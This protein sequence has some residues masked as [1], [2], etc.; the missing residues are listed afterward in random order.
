EARR[1]KEVSDL[2]N[3]GRGSLNDRMDAQR[4]REEIQRARMQ[5]EREREALRTGASFASITLSIHERTKKSEIDHDSGVGAQIRQSFLNG[6]TN[7]ASLW[8]PAVLFA[9]EAG[10]TLIFLGIFFFLLYRFGKR[11]VNK[12]MPPKHSRDWA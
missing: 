2:I 7:F 1:E 4:E 8:L 11:Y 6:F 5:Y 9:G 3:S 12:N 10:P